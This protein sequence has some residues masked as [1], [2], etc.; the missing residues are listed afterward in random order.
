MIASA[1][2][3][4]AFEPPIQA[5]PGRR[6]LWDFVQTSGFQ[7]LV[8]GASKDPNAKVTILLVSPESGLPVLAVKVPTTD[9]AAVAVDTEWRVLSHLQTLPAGELLDTIPRPIDV[10]EFDGR[11]AVVTTAVPGTPM[12]T[13]YFRGRHRRSP[14]RV[15]ADFAAVDNW[16]SSFRRATAGE[17]SALEMDGGVTDRLRQRFAGEDRLEADLDRLAEI[18]ATLRRETVPRTAVH[19]DFWFGNLLLADGQVTGVVDWEA[20]VPSGE[21]ARDLARFALMY[22]LYLGGSARPHR[23]VPG[24]P[25]IRVGAWGAA[26]EYALDGSGWFPDLFRQFLG[27]GLARLG[28]SP[29][30]WRGLALAGIA[31]TAAFTDDDEFAHLHLDLFSQFAHAQHGREETQ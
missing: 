10:L 7:C 22:A 15:A 13:S 31:E 17:P 25:A 1:A 27:D 4:T 11:Q 12:T 3:E 2:V 29:S 6:S 9:R 16:L 19:G 30:A 18:H 24:H 5:A 8:V 21:P 28:A 20:G 14:A 26:I 23:G